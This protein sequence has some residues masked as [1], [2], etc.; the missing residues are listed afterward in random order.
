MLEIGGE[1]GEV[2]AANVLTSPEKSP[3][4]KDARRSRPLLAAAGS[5]VAAALSRLRKEHATHTNGNCHVP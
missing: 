4:T 3:P 2:E 5:W 1:R